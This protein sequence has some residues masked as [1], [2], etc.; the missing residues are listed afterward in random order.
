MFTLMG[1]GEVELPDSID[2]LRALVLS[3]QSLLDE[4]TSVLDEKQSALEERN[5]RIETLEEFV[6]ASATR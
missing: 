3:Q 6:L 5:D 1:R 2:E 4:Q